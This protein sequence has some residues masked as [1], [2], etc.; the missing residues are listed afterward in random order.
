V[1]DRPPTVL[2]LPFGFTWVQDEP[3]ARA[4]HALA[5]GGR[6][7]LIDPVD[8]PGMVQRA[9]GLGDV[10]AVVQLL[11]RHNRDCAAIAQRLGVAHLRLPDE[12]PG[13]P[14]EVVGVVA[15]RWWTEKA[16]W[17]PAQRTLVVSEALG[18][19]PWFT[20]GADPLGV[21]VMLRPAPPKVLRGFSPDRV[22]VGHGPG[23]E[24]DAAR[25]GVRR[26]LGSARRDLP[27]WLAGLPKL[28]RAQRQTA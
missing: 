11:D 4:S 25:N 1:T 8:A 24:G 23:V 17:W 22:L 14:F 13:S 2:E 12:I 19:T 5:D 3:M 10:A 9:Q 7:W 15:L 20:V 28:L 18:T 16:L 26:A 27:R 21:H 6:V